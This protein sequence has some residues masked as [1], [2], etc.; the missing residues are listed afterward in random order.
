MFGF[1]ALRVI[2]VQNVACLLLS[3]LRAGLLRCI[4]HAT[5]ALAHLRS[6]CLGQRPTMGPCLG[7]LVGPYWSR[8]WAIWFQSG[9][10][11]GGGTVAWPYWAHIGPDMGPYWDPDGAHGA[12]GMRRLRLNPAEQHTPLMTM[13]ETTGNGPRRV[14]NIKIAKS[15]FTDVVI[16]VYI[17]IYPQMATHSNPRWLHLKPTFRTA[18]LHISKPCLDRYLASVTIVCSH[19][20]PIHAPHRV[21]IKPRN[22]F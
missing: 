22:P 15:A 4:L 3:C 13:N 7:P 18:N 9:P 17:Y 19:M 12:R 11:N 21:I 8:I 1:L 16:Y 6:L 2:G 20:R 5:C 10:N 14:S